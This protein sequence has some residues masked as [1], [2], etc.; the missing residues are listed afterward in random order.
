MLSGF[1][2]LNSDQVFSIRWKSYD[3]IIRL[4]LTELAALQPG[5]TTLNLI[6]RL[7]S[8]IPPQGFNERHEMGW[9]FIDSTLHKT[10]CRK[11]ELC[12][13]CQDEQQL[14]WTAVENGYSRLLQ[15]CDEFTHLQPHYVKE[16]LELKSRAA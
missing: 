10:I 9:G 2:E 3:E 13:L 11:L 8:H 15:C 4:A 1:I 5:T 7:E 6:T 14:F 12:N 16:L